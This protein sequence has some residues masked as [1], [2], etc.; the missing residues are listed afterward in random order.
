MQAE[1][2][3][4]ETVDP[5]PFAS[6]AG[7]IRNGSRNRDDTTQTCRRQYTSNGI[8]IFFNRLQKKDNITRELLYYAMLHSK[9]SATFP[10]V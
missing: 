9:S 2:C 5:N 4:S 3:L 10:T 1:G 7:K 8:A 6:T